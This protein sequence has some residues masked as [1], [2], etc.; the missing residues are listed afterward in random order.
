MFITI[1]LMILFYFAG[2]A[3]STGIILGQLGIINTEGVSN[4]PSTAF[5]VAIAVTALAAL[6]GVGTAVSIGVFKTTINET[7]ITAVAA[8]VLVTFIGDLI[9]IVSY[10]G[11]SGNWV[12]YLVILIMT[13]II[14]GYVMALYDWVRGRD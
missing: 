10:A 2:L 14:F 1:G 8:L 4:I 3:T 7:A 13:P 11:G 12:S 6:I 5:Y 9:S